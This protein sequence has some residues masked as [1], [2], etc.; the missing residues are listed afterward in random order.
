M[1][2]SNDVKQCG[3][4]N[5]KWLV[6]QPS[7][8]PKPDLCSIHQIE[9]PIS[10]KLDFYIHQPFPKVRVYWF[11]RTIYHGFISNVIISQQ[12]LPS[13]IFIAKFKKPFAHQTFVFEYPDFV[14]PDRPAV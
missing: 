13:N 3:K 8:F 10:H 11:L 2:S 1:F 4:P 14:Q 7:V 9:T 12:L 6:A 5:T